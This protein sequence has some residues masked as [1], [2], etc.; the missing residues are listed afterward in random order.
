MAIL[1]ILENTIRLIG[2]PIISSWGF[3]TI[4]NSIMI[5]HQKPKIYIYISLI[6]STM[7]IASGPSLLIPMITSYKDIFPML[8]LGG[9]TTN[10]LSWVTN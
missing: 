5:L 6:G 9:V 10:I 4:Q 1:T 2:V 3:F 8:F 7:I